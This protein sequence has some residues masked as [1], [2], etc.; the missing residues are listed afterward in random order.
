MNLVLV[1]GP[2]IEPVGLDAMKSYLRVT[3]DSEDAL[4]AAMISAARATVE[5]ITG[6]AL[7]S[8]QWRVSIDAW[9]LADLLRPLLRPLRQIDSARLVAADG[10]ATELE[11]AD[12][13][14]EPGCDAIR[15]LGARPEIAAGGWLEIV[16]TAGY[17]DASTDVPP[18]LR[19]AMQTLAASWFDR[20]GDHVAS[21]GAPLLPEAALALLAPFR[22][23]RLS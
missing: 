21:P 19:L 13:R 2:A 12:F 15:P 22:R 3:D 7:I 14:L 18:P 16:F 5:A 1:N 20:R 23:M 17:G 4:V 9:P 11:A 10:T 6:L 8:Q